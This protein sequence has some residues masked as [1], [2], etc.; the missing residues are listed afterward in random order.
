MTALE[1]TKTRTNGCNLTIE[2]SLW[3]VQ[4]GFFVTFKFC[5]KKL[6]MLSDRWCTHTFRVE[7][8]YGVYIPLFWIFKNKKLCGSSSNSVT[9]KWLLAPVQHVAVPVGT[10]NEPVGEQERRTGLVSLAK[11]R[12]VV[13]THSARCRW[14]PS[15]SCRD[16]DSNDRLAHMSAALLCRDTLTAAVIPQLSKTKAFRSNGEKNFPVGLKHTNRRNWFRSFLIF[17]KL[18]SQL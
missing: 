14:A 16:S 6:G 4:P 11:S 15:V 5:V 8:F 1:R 7:L 17:N 13:M 2:H 3:R 9:V 18:W 12:L 10:D